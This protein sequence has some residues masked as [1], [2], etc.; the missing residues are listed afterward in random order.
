MYLP[1][2]DDFALR[3]VLFFP[4]IYLTLTLTLLG[5]NIG[6]PYNDK[7]PHSLGN[8][9]LFIFNHYHHSGQRMSN[10][11]SVAVH[12]ADST[13]RTPAH[14]RG[15]Y[16]HFARLRITSDTFSCLGTDP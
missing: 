6:Q 10:V 12:C 15:R 4:Y 7:L 8:L 5:N 16:M 11:L 1:A 2:F 3:H 13:I 14:S 9:S